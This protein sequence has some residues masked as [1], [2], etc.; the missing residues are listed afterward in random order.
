MARL[1]G[2]R[3]VP[4]LINGGGLWDINQAALFRKERIWPLLDQYWTS[5]SLL[6]HGNG[7]NNS[8]TF[9]DSSSN[10]FTVNRT[11]AVISTA[12]SKFGGSSMYFD[13]DNDYLTLG[14][15]SV[16]AM[17]TGDFTIELFIYLLEL[18]DQNVFDFRPAGGN[19]AYPTIQTLVNSTIRYYA[20]EEVKFTA[21]LPSLNTWHHL[22][23][24]R[25]GATTTLYL[26]GSA[27]GSFTDTNNY[28]VGADRPAIASGGGTIGSATFN[29]YMDEFRITKGI[30]RYTGDFT[31]PTAQFS[32]Q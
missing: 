8:T 24:V 23:L 28:L 16:L 15:Q 30:A 1:I 32:D 4:T 9:I 19:G 3:N 6:L 22:A 31:A 26:N 25:Y 29:G 21:S 27:V 20:N 13:G 11:N 14:G 7:E 12:Q 5:V 10:A 18:R 2:T 17:G